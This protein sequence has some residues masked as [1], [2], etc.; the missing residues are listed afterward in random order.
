M[1]C[2]IQA[3]QKFETG[4]FYACLK[5]CMEAIYFYSFDQDMSN[6]NAIIDKLIRERAKLITREFAKRFNSE[7]KDTLE[8]VFEN[9]FENIKDGHTA[10]KIRTIRNA[11][12]NAFDDVSVEKSYFTPKLQLIRNRVAIVAQKVTPTLDRKVRYQ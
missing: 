5:S 11:V 4:E 1:G 3:N 8:I 6:L 7:S 12:R 10:K 2:H 9:I